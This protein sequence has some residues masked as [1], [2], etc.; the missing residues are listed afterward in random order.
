MAL[1]PG[2]SPIPNLE[3]ET[4]YCAIGFPSQRTIILSSA[5]LT[6]ILCRLS[7]AQPEIRSKRKSAPSHR[8]NK[9]LSRTGLKTES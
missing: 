5:V 8:I 3:V 4:G 7:P 1:L 9:A 6:I 2:L